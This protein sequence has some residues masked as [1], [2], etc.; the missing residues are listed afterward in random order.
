MKD[1]VKKVAVGLATGALVA[2]SLVIPSF[3]T[4]TVVETGN[5]SGSHN[6]VDLSHTNTTVVDQSNTA[7]ISNKIDA[8][9]NSG[10]N[11][12]KG[13]TG[14][15][16]SIDTGSADSKVAVKNTVNTNEANVKCGGCPTDVGVQISGN[17]SDSKNKVGLDLT[18]TTRVDQTNNA[19]IDN[20]VDAKANTGKN[21]A[22]DNT[23]GNVSINTGDASAWALVSNKANANVADVGNGSGNNGSLDL[24]ITGNGSDSKNKIDADLSN[25]TWLAQDNWADISNDVYVDANTGKNKA[26]DNTGG[27][28]SINTGNADSA[29]KV[30][31]MANFNVA[32]VEDCCQF[33]GF[34]KEGGNGSDS[35]NKVDLDLT[36]VLVD[37][38]HNDFSCGKDSI[39]SEFDLNWRKNNCNDVNAKSN[40]GKNK[41]KD[42]T[43]STHGD[44][45]IDTGNSSNQVEVNN[46]GNSNVFSTGD[47]TNS[48]TPDWVA[49]NG[50]NGS[51]DWFSWMMAGW[52]HNG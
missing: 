18:N 51:W 36:S 14:G 4:I 28:A 38:Q 34:I 32:H 17:G 1:L 45:T 47:I 11:Q 12:V 3:A 26:K 5:G 48:D 27:S 13:N 40:T 20:K 43:S 46:T 29:A 42:N 6:D 9:A 25:S 52:S 44:P 19:T 16:V 24:L 33:D 23:G 41:L 10:D 37:T 30:D 22:K 2:Q 35:K 39:W 8:K 49:Q 31:N 15:D 7:N 50:S 21:N